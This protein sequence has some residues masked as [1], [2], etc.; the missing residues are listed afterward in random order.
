[1]VFFILFH[2]SHANEA[3]PT[4]PLSLHSVL[5]FLLVLVTLRPTIDGSR[6]SIREALIKASFAIFS[7]GWLG[8]PNYRAFLGDFV[9]CGGGA[10][11]IRTVAG[12]PWLASQPIKSRRRMLMSKT[13][14]LPQPPGPGRATP[15]GYRHGE[16][17]L[18]AVSN[19]P[20]RLSPMDKTKACSF[21]IEGLP[22][23]AGTFFTALAAH[24]GVSPSVTSLACLA[25]TGAAAGKSI[26]VERYPGACAA[27][28]LSRGRL[29]D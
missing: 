25:V 17:S 5:L 26:R 20:S 14:H 3:V 16:V 19:S 29:K 22:E 23:S 11:P 24:Y 6:K 7:F 2:F 15:G 27:K 28:K 9:N 12:F 1:M 21:P 18:E 4:V 8:Y 13:E 10:V